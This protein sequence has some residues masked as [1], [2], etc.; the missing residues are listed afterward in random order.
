MV[1]ND[2]ALRADGEVAIELGDNKTDHDD[3]SNYTERSAG[4]R[5][6]C[7]FLLQVPLELSAEHMIVN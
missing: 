7:E 6:F 1:Q 4:E 2:L 3:G 5:S